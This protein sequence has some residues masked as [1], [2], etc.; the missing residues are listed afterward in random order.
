M[1]SNDKPFQERRIRS[2]VRREG[3]ITAGQQR[4]LEQLWPRFGLETGTRLDL[5]AVFDRRARRTLEI[6][7][8][9]GATL[10]A[11]AEKEPDCDFIGIE[12]HRPGVGRLLLELENRGLENVRIFRDD[13]VQVLNECIPDNSL[14]RLLLFFPDP[15]HKKRHH[16]RRIVQPAFL[17]LVARKLVP[18]GILH[19]ATDWENYAE[20]MLAVSSASAAFRNCAGAGRF[21][22]RPDY[23]PVTKF[24]QRGQRRGHGVWDLV[25]E[26]VETG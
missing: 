20:H 24:E 21:S 12:V 16:K 18:G 3:R 19:M 6:G 14:D 5:D 2:F 10:A 9:N 11:M 22:P 4:A 23:R 13:A 1:T 15:W 26:R 17:A 25:F 7:F 8:G